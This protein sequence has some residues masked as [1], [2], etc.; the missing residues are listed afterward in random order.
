MVQLTK[1]QVEC[2]TYLMD[3]LTSKQISE[4]MYLSEETVNEHITN[5]QTRLKA[6]NRLEAVIKAIKVGIITP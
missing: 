1:R 3:G 4:R 2:L 5:A 6:K